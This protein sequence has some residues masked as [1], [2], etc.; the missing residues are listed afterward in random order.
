M[1][2]L[3][4]RIRRPAPGVAGNAHD[5]GHGEQDRCLSDTALGRFRRRLHRDTRGWEQ[6]TSPRSPWFR[7]ISGIFDLRFHLVDKP[8]MRGTGSLSEGW[9]DH[10]LDGL[11]SAASELLA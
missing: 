7:V 4:R 5:D 6:P 8:A 9:V 1:D 10:G 2:E 3:P 11:R